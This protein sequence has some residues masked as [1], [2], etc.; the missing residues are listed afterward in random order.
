M[1]TLK[2]AVGLYGYGT[3][4]ASSNVVDSAMAGAPRTCKPANGTGEHV[5]SAITSIGHDMGGGGAGGIASSAKHNVTVIT[6]LGA[7]DTIGHLQL[8]SRTSPAV[9]L[10]Y[11][12]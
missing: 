3:A 8:S 10:A 12:A 9:S 2:H 1:K 7:A 4:F 11:A 6:D 5:K